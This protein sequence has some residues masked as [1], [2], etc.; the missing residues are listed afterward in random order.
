MVIPHLEELK[1]DHNNILDINCFENFYFPELKILDLQYNKINIIKVFNKVNFHELE[2]LNLNN[3]IIS[4]INPLKQVTFKETLKELNLSNNPISDFNM[5]NLTY[6]PSLEKVNLLTL[7]D[8]IIDSALKILSIKFRLYGYD[9]NTNNNTN[10]FSILIAPFSITKS[11]IWDNKSFDY[12][13]S[14]KIIANRG[15]NKEEIIYYFYQKIL[16]MNDSD[17]IKRKFNLF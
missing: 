6:F 8:N 13:N 16:V 2:I 15:T 14:F 5:L 1:L 17:I 10:S 7:R 3:N 11:D 4:D 9:L 12:S